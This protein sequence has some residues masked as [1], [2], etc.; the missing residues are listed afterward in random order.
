MLI[1][2]NMVRTINVPKKMKT[3]VHVN[4]IKWVNCISYTTTILLL[5]GN[6]II[7]S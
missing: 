4:I 3:K 7:S 6:Y 5:P 2:Y 1:T